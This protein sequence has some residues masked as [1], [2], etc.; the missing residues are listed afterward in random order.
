MVDHGPIV[1]HLFCTLI[2]FFSIFFAY[3]L[4]R[5]NP[6]S[7]LMPFFYFVSLDSLLTL[8]DVIFRILPAQLTVT[9]QISM[10]PPVFRVLMALFKLPLELLL[11]YF[12]MITIIK[13]YN[14]VL[15][16]WFLSLFWVVMGLFF[17][18]TL[19]GAIQYF[20]RGTDVFFQNLQF[21]LTVVLF[22]ILFSS[23][24]WV[25]L[26][27]YGKENSGGLYLLFPINYLFFFFFQFLLIFHSFYGVWVT[28]LVFSIHLPVLAL[29]PR[30]LRKTGH[31]PMSGEGFAPIDLTTFYVEKGISPREQEIVAYLVMGHSNKDIEDKLFISRRTVENHL[32]KVYRKLKVKNRVQLMSL[33]ER[34]KLTASETQ[35]IH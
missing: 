27:Y 14:Q 3:Q 16:R 24:L 33:V 19:L 22:V 18:A 30:H 5:K 17:A 20:D 31:L 26:R 2:A 11:F 13:L 10:V 25:L 34:M 7:F 29:L 23:C 35:K 15:K 1:Y 6:H 28:A 32:Y 4:S 21:P 9:G 8:V 12:F